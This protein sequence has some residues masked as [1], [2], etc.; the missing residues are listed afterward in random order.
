MPL[1]NLEHYHGR[2]PRPDDF[3]D[4]WARAVAELDATPPNVELTAAEFTSRTADAY[5]LFFTGVRGARVYAK[6]LVP[7]STSA[8]PAVVAFHGYSG[9]SGDWCEKLHLVSE[10]FVVAA[11]DVRGQGGM[12]TDPGGHTGTTFFGQIIRGATD[13]ADNLLYR[14]IYLDCARLARIVA[15]LPEVDASRV[16]TLGGSQGGGLALACAALEP[17]I[18]RTAVI[19]PFL[20]D[21]LR[22]WELDLAKSAYDGLRNHFRWFD[23]RHERKDEFFTTMGYID[24]QHLASRIQGEVL[25]T[26]GLMD[27]ICP[28][29]TQ[30]AAYN[31]IT[32]PKQMIIYPDFGHEHVYPGW[33]DLAFHFLRRV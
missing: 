31:K 22:V 14:H 7:K 12:S 25:M 20:C 16:C 13:S 4:Y 5:D 6:L 18:A 33:P 30:F 26:V 9:N 15:N 21:W 2:N 11:M 3:D 32:A 1:E 17:S 8:A 24:V 28:P 27:E 19:Y 10:G 23:P 29:S